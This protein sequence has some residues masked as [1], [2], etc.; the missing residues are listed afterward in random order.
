MTENPPQ[1]SYHIYAKEKCIY[2]NLPE[3]EFLQVWDMLDKFL[4]VSGAMDKSDIT[5]E[6]IVVH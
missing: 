2:Q 3:S 5:Y 1:K 4:T 6:E